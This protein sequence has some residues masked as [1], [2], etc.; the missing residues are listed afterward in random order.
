[1][2]IRKIGCFKA[3]AISKRF[4]F[5]GSNINIICKCPGD[6]KSEPQKFF[7]RKKLFLY[8]TFIIHRQKTITLNYS[9]ICLGDVSRYE[10]RS[11]PC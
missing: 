2:E 7:P 10:Y 5:N 9:I 8:F 4:I 11:Q 6:E 3:T 1:M